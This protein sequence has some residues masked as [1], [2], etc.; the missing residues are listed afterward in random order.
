MCTTNKASFSAVVSSLLEEVDN[1]N[2][3][4]INKYNSLK[5]IIRSSVP[6]LA[7]SSVLSS[8]PIV[9]ETPKNILFINSGAVPHDGAVSTPGFDGPIYFSDN[10]DESQVMKMAG[11]QIKLPAS[12]NDLFKIASAVTDYV[13][14]NLP[15]YIG[16][17]NYICVH[18]NGKFVLIQG[19]RPPTNS[20]PGS[21]NIGAATFSYL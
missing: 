18:G 12:Q 19:S 5:N 1:I 10:D 2:T 11:D 3:K 4:G 7:K 17:Y 16:K 15:Q 8:S 21:P 14:T 20:A 9:D 13:N 6:I